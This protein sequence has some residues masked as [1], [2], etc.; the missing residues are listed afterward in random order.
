MKLSSA[1]PCYTMKTGIYWFFGDFLRGQ[2]YASVLY[3][4]DGGTLGFWK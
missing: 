2:S 1:M 4:L 3:D